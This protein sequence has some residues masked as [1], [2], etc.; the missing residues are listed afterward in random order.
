M[1]KFTGSNSFKNIKSQAI[2]ITQKISQKE[3]KKQNK[4]NKQSSNLMTD[5]E[6]ELL[7]EEDSKQNSKSSN[8]GIV[9]IR[10]LDFSDL[11][12]DVLNLIKTGL[13]SS[14]LVEKIKLDFSHINLRDFLNALLSVQPSISESSE[15]SEIQWL[16]SQTYA[17]TIKYLTN[18]SNSSELECLLYIHD[19]CRINSYP[20]IIWK[21]K[22][23]YFIRILFQTLLIEDIVDEQTFW[24]WQEYI[25]KNNNL[26]DEKTADML[27]IQ[28][29]EFFLLL[30]TTFEKDDQDEEDE[31]ESLGF[32]NDPIMS[33]PNNKNYMDDNEKEKEKEHQYENS[34]DKNFIPEE[35]DYNMDDI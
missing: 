31:D 34:D 11:N 32:D 21:G 22:Q 10:Q 19:Y 18:N 23:T 35:Q 29:S 25:E 26:Y 24:N 9:K 28:T 15:L 6:F 8:H 7:M 33:K 1:S 16:N 12:Q 17:P 5:N 20:K 14:E 2:S 13:V 30:K 3:L 27:A 4:K